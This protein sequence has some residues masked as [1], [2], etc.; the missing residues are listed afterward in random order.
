MQQ[1][2][3]PLRYCKASQ[4]HSTEKALCCT[5]HAS[6]NPKPLNHTLRPHTQST[7]CWDSTARA[8]MYHRDFSG[9]CRL[10]NAIPYTLFPIP[11]SGPRRLLQAQRQGA[12]SPTALSSH[13]H[14]ADD[15]LH[16]ALQ[17]LGLS[18]ISQGSRT[19]QAVRPGIQTSYAA[20]AAAAL[21]T[22]QGPLQVHH[23]SRRPQL[24][25]PGGQKSQVCPYD[26]MLL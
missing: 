22:L 2:R 13:P 12:E 1:V 4:H 7:S 5:T 9:S 10:S 8:V 20:A 3:I 21:G 23:V 24:Y 19:G 11:S 26:T 18:E 16:R 15:S 25:N 17:S 14:H 6:S